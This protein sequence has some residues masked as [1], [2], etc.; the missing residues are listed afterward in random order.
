MEGLK[1][2]REELQ[3]SNPLKLLSIKGF[4]H[5]IAVVAV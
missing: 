4:Y 1:R 5:Q 3:L 2:G